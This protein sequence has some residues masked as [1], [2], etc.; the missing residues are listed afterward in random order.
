MPLFR[1][2]PKPT[3][4][5]AQLQTLAARGLPLHPDRTIDDLLFSWPREQYEAE[6]CTLLLFMLGS[7]VEDDG[8]G[9]F[10]DNIYTFD[11]ECIEDTG[12]YARNIERL[13]EIAAP[14]LPLQSISDE[15]DIEAGLAR[16][17]FTLDGRAHR[18]DQAF[19]NDWFDPEVIC[20][21]GRLLAARPTQ[22]RFFYYDTGDQNI[23]VACLTPAHA[24]ALRRETGL[25]LL[26]F[27]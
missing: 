12:D 1:K 6:P 10:S 22:R 15:I 23:L 18:I 3:P 11:A 20:H 9:H 27:A 24:K 17:E 7:E 2:K 14:D 4:L 8:G 19:N 26:R 16:I 21:L 25:R 5:E 13:A